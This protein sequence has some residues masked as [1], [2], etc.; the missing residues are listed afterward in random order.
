[1]V[2]A[3][4]QT[5]GGGPTVTEKWQAADLLAGAYALTLPVGA[6]LL[7]TYL[8][9]GTLPVPL[10]AQVAQAGRYTVEA[11]ASGYQT[12]SISRDISAA[13]V[14]QDFALVP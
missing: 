5:F 9:G 12:Q 1:M 11:S 3:A 6:P 8:V 14:I 10:G 7:G 13:S 4:G 2:V